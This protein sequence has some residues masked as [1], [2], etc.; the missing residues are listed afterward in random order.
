MTRLSYTAEQLHAFQLT[1]QR[2][3]RSLRK[4]LFYHQIWYPV[5]SRLHFNHDNLSPSASSS[6]VA[7]PILTSNPPPDHARLAG[8]EQIPSGRCVPDL[9]VPD[10]VR[11]PGLRIATWNAR[12][13]TDKSAYVAHTLQ[14]RQLDVL[15]ITESW[16]RGSDDVPLLRAAP[17][18][19]SIHERP[20]DPPPDGR[21][22]RGGGIAVYYRSTLRSSP[23]Q[24]DMEITTFEALCL[25]IATS[26]G[27]STLLTVYRPGSVPPP[28]QESSLMSSLPSWKALSHEILSWS[29]W[30][31]LIYT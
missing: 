29:F 16:H 3:Q 31:I 27:S 14:E 24:L 22:V 12:S 8:S 5:A 11:L 10:Y 20:R 21:L 17:L 9:P 26:H 2:P 25:T 4:I 1:N 6:S 28:P 13:L 19:F 7:E 15:A 30:V 23:V 18:D